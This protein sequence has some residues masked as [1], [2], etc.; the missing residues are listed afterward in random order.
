MRSR[1]RL[2]DV[3][4]D[5]GVSPATVSRAVSQPELLAAATLALVQASARKL[6][7]VPDGAAQA[8]ASGRTM[9]VAAVM[10]TLDSIIFAKALQ[11]MQVA[12][13]AVGYQLLVASHEYSVGAEAEAVRL[14]LAR[15][16]DGLILVGAERPEATNT[17]LRQANVPVVLTWCPDGVN[18]SVTVDNALAGRLAAEHLIR[19]GHRR[20]GMVCGH[21]LFNDRQRARLEGVRAA[22]AEA[23]LDLPDWRISHQPMTI[24]GGRNG[25]SAL[26]E[27]ADRPTALIGGIDLFALG[28]IAEAQ[29]RG[30][31]VPSDLSVVGIDDTEMA[32][33]VSPSL[34]SVH[35]PTAQIGEMAALTLLGR[36]RHAEPPAD[37]L[38]PINLIVRRS[39]TVPPAADALQRSSET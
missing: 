39:S 11:S 37:R 25:C 31:C 9:T 33:Q 17:L 24:S 13:S 20:I 19:L 3:A 10:P 23:G 18:A 2:I 28:S 7:Y 32:S 38:L 8:L 12:L 14:L 27:C 29:A 21:L 22:L 35:I 6:G 1:P 30:L 4:R 26:L 16:I 5:A 36:I 34:T 15:G